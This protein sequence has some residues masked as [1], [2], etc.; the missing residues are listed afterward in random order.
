[1]RSTHM[2]EQIQHQNVIRIGQHG[3]KGIRNEYMVTKECMEFVET[4]GRHGR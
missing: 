3:E 4:Y 2:G 1:M